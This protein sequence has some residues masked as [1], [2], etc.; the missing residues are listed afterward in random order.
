MPKKAG[1]PPHGA[2]SCAISASGLAR[3]SQDGALRQPVLGNIVHDGAHIGAVLIGQR[4]ALWRRGGRQA[5]ADAYTAWRAS[6]HHR[7]N[8]SLPRIP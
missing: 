2:A 5:H 1:P 7:T 6:L 8:A 3:R 4:A